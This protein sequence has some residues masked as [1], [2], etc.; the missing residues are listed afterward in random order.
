MAVGTIGGS[1]KLH[2]RRVPPENGYQVMGQ[3][4]PWYVVQQI[5]GSPIVYSFL[6]LPSAVS[7]SLEF[8]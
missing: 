1:E 5:C 3:V 7:L 8:E 4:S 6:L 2:R